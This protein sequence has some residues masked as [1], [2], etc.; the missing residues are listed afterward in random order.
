MDNRDHSLAEISGSSYNIGPPVSTSVRTCRTPG[1]RIVIP[2][3]G[4]YQI[5]LDRN[6]A[7]P[8]GMS[9]ASSHVGHNPEGEY[10]L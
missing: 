5:F 9:P 2:D 4:N 8:L 7:P 10:W 3:S 6:S 1:F